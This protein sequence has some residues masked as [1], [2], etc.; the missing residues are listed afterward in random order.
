MVRVRLDSIGSPGTY[1]LSITGAYRAGDTTVPSGSSVT[2]RA[3]G[4]EFTMSLKGTSYNMGSSFWL[5]R[6]EGTGSVKIAQAVA[7]ANAYPGDLRFTYQGGTAYVIC[8]VFIEDYLPGV[9]GYEMSD[10]FP[11]EALKAQA[12]SARTYAMRKASVS[13]STYYDLRDT[14]ADQVYRGT[15]SGKTNVKSAVEGTAGMT[16]MYNNEYCQVYYSSSNGGQ[17]ETNSHAWGGALLPYYHVQD[18]PYDLANTSA[19]ARKGTIYGEYSKNNSSVQAL[20]SQAIGSSSISAIESLEPAT[21]R[22]DAPSRLY[23]QMRVRVRMNDGSSKEG[24]VALFSGLDGAL[25]LSMSGSK[26]ELFYVE[27]ISGGFR[28]TARRYG[29]SVG[30]SQYG[31]Q[32]MA[33]SGYDYLN[34]MGFYFKGA[35][36]V[37]HSY[38]SSAASGGSVAV[39]EA[40]AASDASALAQSISARVVLD[41]PTAR[42]NLRRSPDEGSTILAKI[43]NGSSI[44]V[45]SADAKGW[46]RASY[47]GEIGYVVSKYVQ[48]AAPDAILLPSPAAAQ[49]AQIDNAV[50]ARVSASGGSG[51]LNLRESPSL[52]ARIITR[53][54]ANAEVKLRAADAAS[55][56]EW[57]IVAYDGMSG[58]VMKQYLSIGGSAPIANAPVSAVDTSSAP[59]AVSQMLGAGRV[60]VEKADGHLNLREAPDSSARILTQIPQGASVDVYATNGAWSE[61]R[62]QGAYGYAAAQYILMNGAS[63]AQAAANALQ[64]TTAATAATTTTSSAAATA[65]AASAASSGAGGTGWIATASGAGNVNLRA[66]ASSSATIRDRVP[67]GSAVEILDTSGEW[68]HIK[69]NGRTGYVLAE[70]ILTFKP[71][72]LVVQTPQA[73]PTQVA[74]QKSASADLY[75]SAINTAKVKLDSSGSTLNMRDSAS[76]GAASVAKIPN[77]ASVDILGYVNGGEWALARYNNI[78]GF[79]ALDYLKLTYPTATV[80]LGGSGETVSIRREPAADGAFITSVRSGAM[81]TVIERGSEW[82]QVCADDG[83]K[84]YILTSALK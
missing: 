67:H 66:K 76:S 4:G 59:P 49:A 57:V 32:Q 11:L 56:A 60:A 42:L 72:A 47:G 1:T 30:L 33:N 62:Y 48:I 58:Y 82:S 2:V 6:A 36:L 22:Y 78:V 19:T 18:D 68:A 37:R 38:T 71:A 10:S 7:P 74:A 26:N 65:S 84:G 73:A 14:T 34:I 77:G 75:G 46:I 17:T 54:P 31:A 29:H 45:E 27:T 20:I 23:T 25:G 79:L 63:T 80:A 16:L 35:S 15:P 83:S 70:Y 39:P 41:D 5:T 28:V 55:V 13:S 50:S 43:P 40:T 81:L 21:P 3:S 51:S 53:I 12:I 61:I 69:Y 64:A 44:N 8:N 9:V 52:E 24:L